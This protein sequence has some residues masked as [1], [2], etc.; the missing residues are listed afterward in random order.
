[1]DGQAS[2]G[3]GKGPADGS[4]NHPGRAMR[5]HDPNQLRVSDDDRHRVAEVLRHAA[6]EGRIDLDELDERLEATYSAKT[7]ADLVPITVDLPTHPATHSAAPV[8]RQ[9]VATEPA[10]TFTSSVAVMSETKRRGVW[11][12]PEQ[13]TAF[14]LMGSVTLDLREAQFDSPEVTINAFSIMGD[15]RIVVNAST[16]VIVDGVAIMAD[17]SESSAKVPTQLTPESPVVR[18][19]G[20]A[21]MAGVSVQRR[22]MPGESRKRLGGR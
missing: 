21:L 22:A 19:K 9:P 18:V 14:S 1:M 5:P 10:V 15:V 8:L 3:A 2:A 12:V 4:G 20:M 13:H 7:Y 11:Q 16:R 17:F 6:G